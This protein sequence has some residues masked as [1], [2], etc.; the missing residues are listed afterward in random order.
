MRKSRSRRGDIS[1]GH[2]MMSVIRRLMTGSEHCWRPRLTRSS[3]K[4][5][6]VGNVST[7]RLRHR[8]VACMAAKMASPGPVKRPRPVFASTSTS[9]SH[10]F[11]PN[12]INIATASF[13][14][15]IPSLSD[16]Q[17]PVTT[18]CQYLHTRI[19]TK[20]GSL[21]LSMI[22]RRIC[23]SNSGGRP[24]IGVIIWINHQ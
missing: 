20:G 5:D 7:T 12:F 2:L 14:V 16:A 23:W 18:L 1:Q 8:E 22:M 4:S 21:A 13:N 9:K 15:V 6:C 3:G 24:V 11:L 19:K 17:I 10:W